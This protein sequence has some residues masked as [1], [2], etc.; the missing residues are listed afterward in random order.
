MIPNRGTNT[1]QALILSLQGN[2]TGPPYEILL[3]L[4][5]IR[6][7]KKTK[8]TGLSVEC[9]YVQPSFKV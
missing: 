8:A 7:E 9:H 4:Q 6:E 2:K 1:T 5:L 3:Q